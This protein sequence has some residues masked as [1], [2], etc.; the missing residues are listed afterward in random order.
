ML[1]ILT[2]FF[3]RKMCFWEE[4]LNVSLDIGLCWFSLYF[5]KIYRIIIF[6]KCFLVIDGSFFMIFISH[7]WYNGEPDEKVLQLVARLRTNGFDANCDVMLMGSRTSIHFKQMMIENMQNS[8]KI[9]VVL[10][11]MYK[12]KADSFKDGVGVEYKYILEDI[13]VNTKKYILV[14]FQDNI[15]DIEIPE[16]LRGREIICLP[17]NYKKLF[18][19]LEDILEYEF[20][21]VNQ[22]KISVKPKRIHSENNYNINLDTKEN[23]KKNEINTYDNTQVILETDNAEANQNSVEVADN[24]LKK[25]LKRNNIVLI[26][27]I[28]CIFFSIYYF[29]KYSTYNRYMDNAR[30]LRVNH[31]YSQA[32]EQYH[33]ALKLA[34]K[35][36][37]NQEL[38]VKSICMEADC[39]F[40]MAFEEAN[41]DI[42]FQYYAK[43][44]GMYSEIINDEKNKNT[45]F[46]VDALSG[47]SYVYSSTG[48]VLD[49]EWRTLI[50]LLWDEV[51]KMGINSNTNNID[52]EL[53]YHGMKAYGAL[54]EYYYTA[55][56]SD[57]S[58]MYNS[59]ITNTALKCYEKYND[60]LNLIRERN[61]E[62]DITTNPIECDK[63]RAQLMIFIARSPNIENANEYVGKVIAICQ[64]YLN[65]ASNYIKDDMESYF[66]LKVLVADGYRILA[67]NYI[68]ED[69]MKSDEYMEMAYSE[70]IPLLYKKSDNV[71]FELIADVSYSLIFT[72]RCSDD[73]LKQILDNYQKLLSS[74]DINEKPKDAALYAQGICESCK[75][76][77]ENYGYSQQAWEMGK[78]LSEKINDIEEFIQPSQRENFKDFY[79]YFH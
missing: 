3:D 67:E 38:C 26:V 39:Y 45:D 4:I 49:D 76:I 71:P 60:L 34:K 68:N 18:Y 1:T 7:A 21:D 19:R 56:K 66:F 16:A 61:K 53:I 62:V 46:Y 42:A 22:Y 29:N 72:G 73:D 55:I 70:L 30:Y 78:E 12:E 58:F 69:I 36:F 59:N 47:L 11:K 43:A 52:D 40:L 28:T 35:L 15:N 32:A 63:I 54:G 33:D 65:D 14:S 77:I 23:C 27:L 37:F 75:Y 64:P 50:D 51:K 31:N 79:N 2:T 20:P 8:D 13:D 44:G 57:Y 25:S 10:S 24:I 41:S 6:K 74:N 9:I 5:N 17:Q 48:S